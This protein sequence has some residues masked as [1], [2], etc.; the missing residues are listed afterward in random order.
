MKK[1]FTVAVLLLSLNVSSQT[2]LK[3]Y[4]YWLV[5]NNNAIFVE[6][7]GYVIA[8]NGSSKPGGESSMWYLLKINFEGDTVWSRI[9]PVP[10]NWGE[11]VGSAEDT[12]G[13]KYIIS[14]KPEN[15]IY[16]FD[17]NWN[18]TY[19]GNMGLNTIL[20]I[21]ILSDNNIL[22]LT[23]DYNNYI[24]H[25]IDRQ[26]LSDIWTSLPFEANIGY[27]SSI[28]ESSTG[29]I[30]IT[31][32]Q[33]GVDYPIG[34]RV[35]Y[36]SGEGSLIHDFYSQGEIF[37]GTIF[38]GENILTLAYH[39]FIG[40]F[41][42]LR[43]YQPDG[44]LVKSVDVGLENYS[45]SNFIKEEDRLIMIGKYSAHK[46][47]EHN[48][49]AC[50]MNDEIVWNYHYGDTVPKNYHYNPFYV[51]KTHDNGYI[52]GGETNVTGIMPYIL[53]VNSSGVL[54]E[55]E[56]KPP[57]KNL[58]FPNPVS[59]VVTINTTVNHGKIDLYSST[60]NIVL[61]EDLKGTRH[62]LDVSNLPPGIYVVKITSDDK[63]SSMKI[64][65]D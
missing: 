6:T 2:F 58:F 52:I 60:G 37:A 28:A 13:N 23:R 48:A 39:T 42:D 30:S 61:S 24:I 1:I 46:I 18:L 32:V 51:I 5:A 22:I 40:G 57:I 38:E 35:F 21:K 16:R 29:E 41:N 17:S 9:F 45:F 53:K 11:L 10:E 49:I 50:V 19:N 27:I 31:E 56:L 65:V 55:N 8:G 7:D 20:S 62:L 44:T 47:Y 34:S 63:T 4:P 3:Y 59:D 33:L 14:Y 54:S 26:T 12:F 43:T 64:V 15:S 25:K 36:L